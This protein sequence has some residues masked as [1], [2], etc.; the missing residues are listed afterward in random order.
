[1]RLPTVLA[2]LVFAVVFAAAD[3][4]ALLIKR[5]STAS[6]TTIASTDPSATSATLTL[7]S[8]S[9]SLPTSNSV[10]LI[11][12]SSTAT[13]SSAT[14]SSSSVNDY[15]DGYDEGYNDGYDDSSDD[16]H[17]D[18]YKDYY[19]A[20]Y[21]MNA[22]GHRDFN[23]PCNQLDII[24]SQCANGP[25][26]MYFF[27]D[28]TDEWQDQSPGTERTCI[29]QSQITDAILGCAA[30]SKAHKFSPW[31]G[32][33]TD[34]W[35]IDW[36]TTTAQ[37]CDVNFTPT[38]S[39]MTF[40]A[41]AYA[42]VNPDAL[43]E[44]TSVVKDPLG[45]STD[46]SLY[47]TMSVTRTD[48]FDI[49]MPTALGG[50]VT[51]TSTRISSGVI[52]PTA[53]NVKEQ[54]P[55]GSRIPSITTSSTLS[56][57]TTSSI[58]FPDEETNYTQAL[59]ACFPRDSTEHRDFNAPCNQAM[60]IQA[61]CSY[62]PRAL[63]VVTL[64]IDGYEA[65]K[66]KSEWQRQSPETERTCICQSQIIDAVLGCTACLVAQHI[67]SGN[68]TI[69]AIMELYCDTDYAV[70]QS[71]DEFSLFYQAMNPDDD[72]PTETY[73]ARPVGT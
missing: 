73:T 19:N 10:I 5:D 29:C 35:E 46:V 30:C 17:E 52:V 18:D 1:M 62:G 68:P 50:E 49:A 66:F 16:V 38:E 24:R 61:Q 69:Q 53:R 56:A 44:I 33:G 6:M 26:V 2:A 4:F 20:S 71:Y 9:S 54:R 72:S 31:T 22:T 48:A 57:R 47:Y 3:A 63:E 37:Y 32:D 41:D 36:H 11:V 45:T 14:T 70:K 55:G 43:A 8:A 51:Y 28:D 15:Y 60:A 23:A 67:Y 65:P 64:P 21:P 58:N 12:T 39:F 34:A 7:T 59:Y 27:S 40:F 42:A 13:D 25:R